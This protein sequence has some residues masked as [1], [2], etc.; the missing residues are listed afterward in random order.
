VA[1]AEHSLVVLFALVRGFDLPKRRRRGQTAAVNTST[2]FEPTVVEVHQAA[3]V[4]AALADPARLRVLAVLADAQRCVCDIQSAAPMA[5]NLLSYHLRT[6]REAGL[7]EGT[8][9]GRFIDYRVT[10][11][12]ATLIGGALTTAGFAAAVDQP[13]GCARDC[14]VPVR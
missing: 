8:R 9:R 3:R 10:A 11:N 5:A 13:A 2:V 6:L 7:I 12:A 1:G 14:A 4:F